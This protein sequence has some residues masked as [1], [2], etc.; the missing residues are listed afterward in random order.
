MQNMVRSFGNTG[1]ITRAD[2]FQPQLT[3]ILN[4]HY[5]K[6]DK[7]FSN[8]IASQLPADIAQTDEERQELLAFLLLASA[9]RARDQAGI[10]TG[11]NQRNIDAAISQA[12]SEETAEPVAVDSRTIAVLAGVIL[13]RSL[14][15]RVSS[16]ACFETQSTAEFA[17]DAEARSLALLPVEVA[18]PRTAGVEKIWLTRGDEKVRRGSIFNHVRANGQKQDLNDPYKV[19]G[20]LLKYPA[21]RSLGATSPNVNGCRCSSLSSVNDI[22]VIRRG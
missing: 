17:K 11:T 8:R 1:T 5:N 3:E 19:S 22:I 10:V 4:A 15:G 20:E 14:A 13:A 16:I 6:V 7:E 21:D 2:A 18:V 12:F 9:A